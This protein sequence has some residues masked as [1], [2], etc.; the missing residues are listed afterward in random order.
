[1]P[2]RI[3]YLALWMMGSGMLERSVVA[4]KVERRPVRLEGSEGGCEGVDAMVV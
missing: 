1:M 3:K 2:S 4:M